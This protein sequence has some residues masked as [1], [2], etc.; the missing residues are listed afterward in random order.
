LAIL[1][2]L[3][4][5][6]NL[7]QVDSIAQ[8]IVKG[9]IIIGALGFDVWTR[10]LRAS[11]EQRSRLDRSYPAAVEQLSPSVFERRIPGS[12]GSSGPEV[13]LDA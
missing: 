11:S 4:N 2:S 12:N 3:Q 13:T 1:A 9:L 7:L 5:G 8:Y 6:L 10:R